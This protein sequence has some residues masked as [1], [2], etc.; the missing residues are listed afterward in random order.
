MSEVK[1]PDTAQFF[2]TICKLAHLASSK[3]ADLYSLIQETINVCLEDMPLTGAVIWLRSSEQAVLSPGGS[4][5]PS[6]CSTS[7]LF[8]GNEMLQ[9]ALAEGS[10][11][12]TSDEAVEFIQLPEDVA[13]AIA[14][15][16]SEDALLGLLGYVAS[17]DIL[18]PMQ[19]LLEANADILSAPLLTAWLRRQQEEANDVAD[20]LFQFAGELRTQRSL[21]A[22]LSTLNN[23]SLRV[24]NCDLAAVYHWDE[25]ADEGTFAPVQI[26]TRIGLQSIDDEPALVLS[27]NPLLELVINDPDINAIHDLR[28]Q[29]NALPVYLQRHKIRGLV[30]VPIL[31][32][33][34]PKGLLLLGY[35]APLVPFSSRSTALALGLARMVGIALER[36]QSS[37]TG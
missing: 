26:M 20:T 14:P 24:F 31:H 22:I 6:G 1:L 4:R 37:E 15:I 32:E 10:S 13:L 36:T 19:A 27:E 34:S 21:E 16:K 33:A 3:T 23:L 30:L 25:E 2:E 35:R 29:P 5:L 11:I 9:K 12:L 7:A 18:I 8:E 17:S 28:T